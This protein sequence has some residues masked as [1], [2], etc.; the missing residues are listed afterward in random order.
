[1]IDPN[2]L[3]FS[4]Q[5]APGSPQD[6]SYFLTRSHC[7]Q[8]SVFNYVMACNTILINLTSAGAIFI[9][10]NIIIR[11]EMGIFQRMQLNRTLLGRPIIIC[12]INQ[13]GQIQY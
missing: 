8:V 2:H 12:Y 5:E 9:K 3:R 7:N 10:Q 6:L 4:D 11:F 1:M 13:R